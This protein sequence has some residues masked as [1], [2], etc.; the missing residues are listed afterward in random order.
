MPDKH[1]KLSP[2]AAARWINCPGS[3]RLSE[4]VPPPPSSDYADEGTLAHAVAETKLLRE[5][6]ILT[7]RIY[8][9]R[10]I[11]SDGD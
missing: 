5:T 2:S 8:N 3:I 11:N 9:D 1:A 4:K 10:I 6:R 7:A